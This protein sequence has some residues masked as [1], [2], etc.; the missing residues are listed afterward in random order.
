VQFI[1]HCGKLLSVTLFP[2]VSNF[3]SCQQND[4]KLTKSQGYVREVSANQ[5]KLSI[6]NFTFGV[7][8]NIC[9]A[10]AYLCY[11]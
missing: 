5:E 9:F 3:G 7:N 10:H 4:R 2:N 11:C 1:Q 8:R 6:T